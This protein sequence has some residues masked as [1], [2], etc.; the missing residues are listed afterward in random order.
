MKAGLTIWGAA[1]CLVWGNSAHAEPRAESTSFIIKTSNLPLPV[2]LEAMPAITRDTISKVMKSP[3]LTTTAQ[4]E[5]F[6][7]HSDMYQWLLDHPDR[8]S[9]AW[10]KLG[11]AASEIKPLKD[12]RFV[13]RDENGSEMV[14]QA[15]AKSD[16]GRIWYAEGKIKPAALSPSF[17][18]SAVAV[19]NHS[20]KQRSTGDHTIKHQVEIFLSTDSK[21]ANLVAKVLGDNAPKMAQQGAEQV[22]M[23]FS[24]IAKYTHDKPEKATTL[25]EE[26]RKK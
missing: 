12:G 7:A 1:I 15:V 26:P 3:T 11:V 17:P 19:L 23:F 2:A 18:V 10:R 24:G 4:A 20:E 8:T 22:L 25:F 6:V 5:E 14:W 16:Q 21:A 13:W 9:A